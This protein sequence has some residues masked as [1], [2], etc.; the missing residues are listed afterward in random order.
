MK[1]ARRKN[2]KGKIWE[3]NKGNNKKIIKKIKKKAE[4]RNMIMIRK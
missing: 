2:D 3:T 4:K 1:K